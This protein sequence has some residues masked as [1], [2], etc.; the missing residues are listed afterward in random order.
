MTQK[1]REIQRSEHWNPDKDQSSL[2]F[3]FVLTLKSTKVN[4]FNDEVQTAEG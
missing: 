2:Q 4:K 1:S 3:C